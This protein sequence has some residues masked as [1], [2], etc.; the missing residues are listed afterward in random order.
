[1][2]GIERSQVLALKEMG[3]REETYA[4][5]GIHNHEMAVHSKVLRLV[6]KAVAERWRRLLVERLL[7]LLLI[8][9]LNEQ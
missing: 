5:D 8:Q 4:M 1:M 6:D 7:T 2:N 9:Q 3:Y